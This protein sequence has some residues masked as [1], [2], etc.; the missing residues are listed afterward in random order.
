MLFSNLFP[1]RRSDVEFPFP[2]AVRRAV[3]SLVLSLFHS[4]GKR[5]LQKLSQPLFLFS[6][7][8]PVVIPRETNV[9]ERVCMCVRER[10]I[11]IDR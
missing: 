3:T 1:S 8:I 10:E 7:Y 11:H 2:V 9:G 6:V 4:F 5:S